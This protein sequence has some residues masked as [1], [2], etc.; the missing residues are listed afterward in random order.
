MIL[1]G[2]AYKQAVARAVKR[3]PGAKGKIVY[4]GEAY[5]MALKKYLRG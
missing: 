5:K 1:P 2:L 3:K 4:P